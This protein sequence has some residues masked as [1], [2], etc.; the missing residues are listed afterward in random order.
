MKLTDKYE[1]N[2]NYKIKYLIRS[3]RILNT[4]Y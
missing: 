3:S 2:H 4:K 1:Y